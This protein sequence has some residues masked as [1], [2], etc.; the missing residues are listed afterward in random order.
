[1]FTKK[2]RIGDRCVAKGGSIA[3]LILY[4]HQGLPWWY[5]R[6]DL[7]VLSVRLSVRD[8]ADALEPTLIVGIRRSLIDRLRTHKSQP[9]H[10]ARTICPQKVL[11][12]P[13]SN[14]S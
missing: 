11:E 14:R 5:A 1:M 4:V 2:L 7:V 10:R 6:L 8:R 13:R 9:P 12:G 3:R